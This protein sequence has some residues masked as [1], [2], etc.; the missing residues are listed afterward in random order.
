MR[1]ILAGSTVFLSVGV[2]SLLAFGCNSKDGGGTV[3][4]SGGGATF[5]DP[6]MQKWS[7]EYKTAK[8]VEID[9]SKS[10]SSDGIK[11]MTEKELDFG[12]SDAPMKKE[13]I[14]TA[15]GKG[16]DVVHVPVI[17]GGVAIIYNVPGVAD[18][19][20]SGPVVAEIYLGWIKKWNDDAIAKLNAG[21]TLP[22]LAI[23]PVYRAEGSGTSNIFTEYLSKVHS[24]FKTKIGL[25]TSP[26]WPEIGTGQ[27]GSDGVANHVK[28]NAGCIGYAEVSYAKSNNIAVAA[29]QNAKGA[30]AKPDAES[31]T[32]AAEWALAQKQGAEPYSLHELT[33]S[34]TNA[35]SGKA[36]PICGFSYAVLY[37]KEPT[38]KGKALV[39]FLKW[40]TTDGQK[41]AVDLHYAPLPA[42]LGKKVAERL[43]Q[44]EF[45]D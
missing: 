12:C 32:A 28:G 2:A 21:V 20:L 26:K 11:K 9:Y 38:N 34:L 15:K 35:E 30:F 42:E 43:N 10:G 4:L 17:A 7:A 13:Q 41:F 36:Y 33:Y 19:K 44:I 27:K 5:V 45:A 16:G 40:V 22:D 31:V 14:E 23:V 37:K 25:S 3:R 6:I 39:E 1:H 18:L 8:G 24:E 29:I